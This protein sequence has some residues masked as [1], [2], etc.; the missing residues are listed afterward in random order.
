MLTGE[1]DDGG[2]GR[3]GARRIICLESVEEVEKGPHQ[4]HTLVDHGAVCELMFPELRTEV[5]PEPP[6]PRAR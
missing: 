4:H 1:G 3:S 5:E 6:P 2:T